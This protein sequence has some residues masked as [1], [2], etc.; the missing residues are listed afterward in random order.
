M[1][2]HKLRFALPLT[3]VVLAASTIAV[4]LA[5]HRSGS[6]SSKNLGRIT[7]SAVPAPAEGS[8]Y[9][10]AAYPAFDVDLADG[11]GRAEV[12]AYCSSCHAT[13]YIL[14]Q[15]PLPAA[16]WDA[17]VQKMVKTF[18]AQISDADAQKIIQYLQSHYTPETRK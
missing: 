9:E 4:A 15:P 14:M 6:Y 17:E 11:P 18:G 5:Q 1:K 8:Q 13:R 10:V 12:Q 3:L 16:T 2:N 7:Q